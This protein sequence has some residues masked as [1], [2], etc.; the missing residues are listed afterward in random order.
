[1][2]SILLWVAL[3]LATIVTIIS[4]AD[5]FSEAD[6]L[7][8]L[9]AVGVFFAQAA[10]LLLI[11]WWIRPRSWRL[12]RQYALTAFIVGALIAVSVASVL[13]DV[14]STLDAFG[15]AVQAGIQEEFVKLASVVFILAIVSRTRPVRPMEG[16]IIG[17][18]VGAGFDAFENLT[19]GLGANADSSLSAILVRGIVGFGFHGLWAGISGWAVAFA[20]SQRP[21]AWWVA[22]IGLIVAIALHISWDASAVAGA[23]DSLI[24]LIVTAVVTILAFVVLRIWAGRIDRDAERLDRVDRPDG[25]SDEDR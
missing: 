21:R 11:V 16:L 24:L 13:P 23:G 19:Y 1:M 15:I 6:V 5:H 14:S 17:F 2:S 20:W 4:F 25:S 12:T 10:I 18:L 3:S 22:V 7:V 8:S 9:F